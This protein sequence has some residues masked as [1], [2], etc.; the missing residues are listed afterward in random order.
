M[1]NDSK[2][3][4]ENDRLNYS[5]YKQIRPQVPVPYNL[6]FKH[7]P[8]YAKFLLANK[9]TDV[10]VEQLKLSRQFKLPLL[11]FLQHLPDDKLIKI[12]ED[13]LKELLTYIA[14]NRVAAYIEIALERWLNNQL[15]VIAKNQIN[16]DDITLL[17]FIR[18]QS[19]RTFIYSY[20]SDIKTAI[21]ILNEIDLFTVTNDEMALKI[22]IEIQSRKFVEAQA[23]ARIGNWQWD[24]QTK[25]LSWS[26]EIYRIYELEPQSEIDSAMI[27]SYNHPDDEKLVQA[28]MLHLTET[29]LPHDFFYR[30]ILKNGREKILHAKGEVKLNDE[31]HIVETFGTLQDVTVQKQKE[32]ELE[33]NTKFIEKIANL[34][35]CIISVYN[36]QNSNYIFINPTIEAIL[37]YSNK[38][39]IKNGRK[40]FF[41]LVHEED[42]DGLKDKIS[43]LIAEANTPG[44]T[45]TEFIKDFKYRLQHADGSYKWIHTFMTVF[46]RDKNNKVETILNISIDV[47][48]SHL[49]TL[50][51]AMANE[52]IRRKENQ[53][54]RMIG[55]V[56]D[57]A[58][59]LM[60]REGII[61]N[62]NKGAEAIQGYSANE[63]VGKSFKV[64]YRQEDLEN[65]L[66]ESLIEE[67]ALKGKATHE[68]W[69]VHKDGTYFWGSVLITALHDDDNNVIGFS[70][71]TRNLTD[72]KMADDKLKE[73][74]ARI[75][76]HN[77]ELVR[78]NKDLDSFSYTASHDLQEPLRK[79]KTFC[80][81]ILSKENE[82]FS[83]DVKNYFSRIESAA[84]RMRELIDSLL[85]YSRTAASAIVL[86]ETDLN[87][88]VHEVEKE[89]SDVIK[90]SK[91]TIE[92]NNLPKLKV[93]PIQIQ[94]LFSNIIGNAIK[95]RHEDVAPV[96]KISSKFIK[97]KIDDEMKSFCQIDI[98]DNGIGF[99]QQYDE[100]IFKLFQRLHGRNEYSGTGIGLAICKKIVENHE[101]QISV[102]S[103]PGKGSTFTILLPAE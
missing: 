33:R 37:G 36:V 95:Y 18:R 72:K 45:S 92:S 28:N 25:K 21:A 96:I 6:S 24:F 49:L 87:D 62:W 56:E 12:G 51:L 43:S 15:P 19:F 75:E 29:L 50:K 35:P 84:E 67:A 31:G 47:T 53:Y 63:I 41:K 2:S 66:P 16:T 38:A 20:T 34:S 102:V 48:E 57:Y 27:A 3:T 9:L 76:K 46:N 22:V 77:E 80:N 64:F 59:I 97:L 101:G 14:D 23:L 13:S 82:H 94:Q 30:I 78:I 86:N 74:A 10:S 83:A 71:V 103:E 11:Q 5:V 88:V 1:K 81:L 93:M 42:I 52:E 61:Q 68:G 39:F 58:I 70:K 40:L 73:Y 85:T 4:V 91:A 7:L 8:G 79:I 26:D 54:Q 98:A 44:I 99:E 32:K 65:K 90:E 55:E 100:A 69:R 89:L 60:N 17:S